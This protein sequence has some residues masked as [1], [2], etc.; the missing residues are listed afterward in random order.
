MALIDRMRDSLFDTRLRRYAVADRV[1]RWRLPVLAVFLAVVFAVIATVD[2]VRERRAFE[3]ELR[4]GFQ[5]VRAGV[6]TGL[7]MSER[8]M[9]FIAAFVASDSVVRRLMRLAHAELEAEGGGGGGIRA[10]STRAQ[11]LALMGP[12]WEAVRSEHDARQLHFHVGPDPVSFLRLHSPDRYGDALD[13]ARPMVVAVNRDRQPRTGFEVGRSFASVR[14]I[15][16]VFA[17]SMGGVEAHVGSVEIG[18]SVGDVLARLRLPSGVNH[19]VLLQRERVARVNGGD[20][21]FTRMPHLAAC[22]CYVAATSGDDVMGALDALPL[23]EVFGAHGYRLW[24]TGDAWTGMI[25]VPVREFADR[26]GGGEIAGAILLYGDRTDAVVEWR[27]RQWRTS[28]WF[29]AAYALAILVAWLLLRVVALAYGSRIADAEEA[30]DTAQ[31]L[32][33]TVFNLAP[34]AILVTDRYGTIL[35]VNPRFC[36]ISGY[37]A[38]ELIGQKPSVLKSGQTPTDVYKD[39]WGRLLAGQEWRGDLL[40]RRK[41]GSLYWDSHA[42]VPVRNRKG[43]ISRFISFQRDVTGRRRMELA[44]AA[45]ERLYRSIFEN[46]EES[47]FL[48]RP[49]AEGGFRFVGA[50]PQH[51]RTTGI[52]TDRLTGA[53]P[54]DVM[55][56]TLAEAV[57]DRYRQCLELGQSVQF[58]EV[59]DLPAGRRHLR[60]GLNPLRGDDGRVEMI[61]G[62]SVDLTDQ[63]MLLASLRE[64]R[65]RAEAISR[66]HELILTSAGEGIFGLDERGRVTFINPAAAEVLQCE[67][68]SALGRDVHELLHRVPGA[69]EDRPGHEAFDHPAASCRLLNALFSGV[70][71]SQVDDIFTTA[72]GVRVPVRLSLT[73]FARGNAVKGAVV[74][75]S[76]VT[77]LRAIE[78]ELRRLAT[79]DALTGLAN[80]RHFMERASHELL[81][82]RRYGQPVS[83]LVL[84]L[85]H[86]KLIND[87]HGHA[88]GDDA[89]KHFSRV[90]RD[91]LRVVDLPARLGGEE[92]AVLMP[93]TALEGA[94]EMAERLRATLESSPVVMAGESITVTTSIGVTCAHA[95][96]LDVGTV[97]ARADAALYAAKRGGRNRVEVRE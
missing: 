45:N 65:E 5:A 51:A 6:E 39:L 55:P 16:P 69:N 92:F 1:L 70:E 84:D 19:A 74:V 46:V 10:A 60:T 95:H 2:F 58:E 89:L 85:D 73:P 9:S 11:L 48:V 36:E 14:A 75:F 35:E 96:E 41:D 66:E 67:M 76:D 53:R 15:H 4:E 33:S 77:R 63:K 78:E 20:P 29:V 59:M 72:L 87:T 93:D 88:T 21:E 8:E 23:R 97:L 13:P 56:A 18:I 83:M 94:I 27:A 24:R 64:S 44:L 79:T 42:I 31:R 28:M 12:R 38:D 49:E 47:I 50:N 25:S 52:P 71:L 32:G 3:A 34:D 17:P 62:L 86:F 40:N 68:S 43:E 22:D 81:R 61:V 82:A 91:Q 54:R 80:R 30:L 57:S 7:A 37:E 90:C 26:V